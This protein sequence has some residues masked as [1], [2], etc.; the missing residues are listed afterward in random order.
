MPLFP[1]PIE[2]DK[3]R[4]KRIASL[5]FLS[6]CFFGGLVFGI[7]IPKD[8]IIQIWSYWGMVC[9]IP[10][11]PKIFKYTFFVG[12]AGYKAGKIATEQEYTEI[13][14]T[15]DTTYRAHTV[16]TNQGDLVAIIVGMLVFMF[17][18]IFYSLLGP[19]LIG[20]KLFLTV[21]LIVKYD[22]HHKKADDTQNIVSPTSG[23]R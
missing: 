21:S 16:R 10:F 8:H 14:Q 1:A 3:D 19:A 7:L 15:S 17:M 11:L 12:K 23:C 9:S 5:I 2:A 4:L 6:A 20:I 13:H 22:K 18:F